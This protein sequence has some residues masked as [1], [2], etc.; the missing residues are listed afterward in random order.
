MTHATPAVSVSEKNKNKEEAS[1][2]R[3]ETIMLIRQFARIYELEP[4][5]EARKSLLN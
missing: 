5:H 2:P 3:I 4:R 1:G